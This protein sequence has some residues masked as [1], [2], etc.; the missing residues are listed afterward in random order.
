MP[1]IVSVIKKA[2]E[3]IM[4]TIACESVP[5]SEKVINSGLLCVVGVCMGIVQA[6]SSE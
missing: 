4:P 2:T 6:S 5:M 3:G 1:T